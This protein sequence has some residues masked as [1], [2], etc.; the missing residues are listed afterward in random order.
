M[1]PAIPRYCCES[2]QMIL[3]VSLPLCSMSSHSTAS[4]TGEIGL[5]ARTEYGMSPPPVVLLGRSRSASIRTRYQ[6]WRNHAPHDP[7]FDIPFMRAE[8]AQRHVRGALRGSLAGN[9]PAEALEMP[10]GSLRVSPLDIAAVGP[11]VADIDAQ[12]GWAALP[13]SRNDSRRA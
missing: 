11:F 9:R 1:G 4:T 12:V 5:A 6:G 7:L 10:D 13:R 8:D 3:T 2:M